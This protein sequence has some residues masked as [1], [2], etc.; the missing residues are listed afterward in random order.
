MALNL[1]TVLLGAQLAGV[2]VPLAALVASGLVRA[3]MAREAAF[4]VK[5]NAPIA[6][7]LVEEELARG[8]PLAEAARRATEALRPTG[9]E[10]YPLYTW[11]YLP[12]EAPLTANTDEAP[13]SLGGLVDAWAGRHDLRLVYPKA[14]GPLTRAVDRAL[15]RGR[16]VISWP[17]RQDGAVVAAVVSARSS[18]QVSRLLLVAYGPLLPMLLVF[19]LV[20]VQLLALAVAAGIAGSFS[21]LASAA[22]RVADGQ[23]D[24]LP[25]LPRRGQI[26]EL[27]TL[28]VD[29]QRM[30]ARLGQRAAYVQELSSNVAHELRT[31]LSTLAGTVELLQDHPDLPDAERGRL[32]SRASGQLTRLNDLLSG[33]L[34]LARVERGAD[35]R[36]VELDALLA[37]VASDLGVPCEGRAGAVRGDPVGLRQVV[38]NLVENALRHG[39]PPVRVVAWVEGD[40]AGFDVLDGGPGVP[41]E[42]LSKIFER[43]FTT[44]RERGLGLGL[45]L[46]QA[47]VAAH[48]GR[49]EVESAPGATRMR[50]VL[51]GAGA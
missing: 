34:A 39:G 13:G 46:V 25:E 36:P 26:F 43:F 40:R 37:E 19:T 30:A 22:R 48:G 45:A 1:R 5:R 42:H 35:L 7:R 14:G 16:V 8:T 32:L 33:L 4:E 3:E 9:E 31:P 15:G 12:P 29:V 21:E 41:P 50:V 2:L 51:W 49:V 28:A 47:I 20:G 6:A 38:H 18:T 23:L 44:D 17:V 11:V 27:D 10:T 24:A